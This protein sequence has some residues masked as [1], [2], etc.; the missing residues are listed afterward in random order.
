M[1][2]ITFVALESTFSIESRVLNKYKSKMLDELPKLSYVHL[3]DYL[4]LLVSLI[5]L[6]MIY[7]KCFFY[8][9]TY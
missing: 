6:L 2:F 8:T 1:H 5:F 9:F 7:N 4:V 3:I